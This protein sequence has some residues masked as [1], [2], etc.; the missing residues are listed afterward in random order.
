M[1]PHQDE[2]RREPAAPH[3]PEVPGLL[4][5]PAEPEPTLIDVLVLDDSRFDA[6]QLQRDCRSTDL[7]VRVSIASGIEEFRQMLQARRYHVV[8]IDYLLPDGDGLAAQEMLRGIEKN[9]Q[10]P[11]VMISG[12][13]RHDVA[14]EAIRSGCIDYKAK[15]DLDRDALKSLILR[16][17]EAGSRVAQQNLQSALEA[18]REEIVAAMRAIVREELSRGVP[19]ATAPEGGAVTLQML[20][21]YGLIPEDKSG[22]W[23]D[24]LDDPAMQFVFRKH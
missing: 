19:D 3:V 8:F 12:E 11:V 14:V 10:A 15:T 4:T 13:A 22:D 18:Q 17:L 23:E 20:R 1:E 9:G 6:L 24:L 5:T 7:P 21:S 2:P 16:A